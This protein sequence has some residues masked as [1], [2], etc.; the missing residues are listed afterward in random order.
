MTFTGS[1]AVF[2][3]KVVG[4]VLDRI[5]GLTLE[6]LKVDLLWAEK[7]RLLIGLLAVVVLKLFLKSVQ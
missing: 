3:S 7:D 5:A 1:L 2:F 6:E 4:F